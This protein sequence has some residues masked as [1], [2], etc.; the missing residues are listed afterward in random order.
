VR[1]YLLIVPND[2]GECIA[3]LSSVQSL[4]FQAD[5]NGKGDLA[6]GQPQWASMTGLKHVELSWP[7]PTVSV[8]A[9]SV[10]LIPVLLGLVEVLVRELPCLRIGEEEAA[11]VAHLV[12]A[13]KQGTGTGVAQPG[14]ARFRHN[15]FFFVGSSDGEPCCKPRQALEIRLTSFVVCQGNSLVNMRHLL[16]YTQRPQSHNRLRS[17]IEHVVKPMYWRKIH[18]PLSSKDPFDLLSSFQN[19]D[20]HI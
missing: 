18:S 2:T 12:K 4:N 6:R 20:S 15:R 19:M 17:R 9:A 11:R 7:S 1:A 8:S 3:I 16:G 10:H 13:L 14:P 5:A